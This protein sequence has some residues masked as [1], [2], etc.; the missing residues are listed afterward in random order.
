[1]KVKNSGR[2]Q[3]SKFEKCSRA[4]PTPLRHFFVTMSMIDDIPPTINLED[5][6]NQTNQSSTTIREGHTRNNEDSTPAR[7]HNPLE[8]AHSDANPHH[9]PSPPV[10]NIVINEVLSPQ[11]VQRQKLTT[12]LEESFEMGYDS[13][14]QVGPFLDAVEEEGEQ[15]LHEKGVPDEIPEEVI[16]E[17]QKST[18]KEQCNMP[19][20][21]IDIFIPIEEGLVEKMK[22]AELR[23]ELNIR[24]L[25]TRG[26]KQELQDRL[27]KDMIDKVHVR[28][29]QPQQKQKK[30]QVSTVGKNFPDTARWEVLVADVDQVKEPSNPTFRQARAPTVS[31]EDASSIP[32]KYNFSNYKFDIPEFTGLKEEQKKLRGGRLG[33][34]KINVPFT[35]GFMK[36]SVIKK[37]KLSPY[38][39]PH[40]WVDVFFPFSKNLQRV[41][42]VS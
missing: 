33:K 15:I 29:L 7:P 6:N 11:M 4:S 35:D 28:K 17:E 12:R 3:P 20:N 40:E 31:A 8:K 41:K 30:K 22:V 9:S 14:E 13:D 36:P 39:L 18:D 42:G 19:P 32:I 24:E 34:E 5:Q 38:S 1:M 2:Y 16:I 37:F 26:K 21:S 23:I 27:R 10:R 25:S